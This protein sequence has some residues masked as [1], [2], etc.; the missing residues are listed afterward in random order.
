DNWKVS[1]RLTLNLGLRWDKWTPYSEKFNRLTTIDKDSVLDRFEVVTPGDHEIHSLP[2]IPPAVLDSWSAAGMTYATANQ[3]GYPSNLFR[4]DNNN[5]GPRLGAAYKITDK[6]VL[7]GGYGEYFWPM[8][9]SQILQSSRTNPP[10]NLRFANEPNFFDGSGTY[11]LRNTP[12][13]QFFL[14]NA[15]VDISGIQN[16]PSS[17]KGGLLW[18]G[19]NWKDARAQSWHVSLE[20]ELM[21][22]TALRLSYI[23]QH[24]RDL[25]QR[26]SINS[27]EAEFNYVLRTGL[28]P[29]GN[30]DQLLRQNP[31]WLG[32][33]ELNRTGFS[34]SHSAQIEIERKYS[35]G[36]AFQWFYTF[37]RS[38]TTTDTG[39]F[40]SGGTSINSGGSTDG[41]GAQVPENIQLFGEPNLTYDE[42]LHFAYFNSTAI[43]AHRIR[44]NG[45]VDLPFGRGKKLGGNVPAALDHV[46]GGWQIATI[47]DWRGGQ[48]SSVGGSR[49][50][51]GDPRLSPDQR[52]EMD[53][54]GTR[55]RLW[56]RG[57]FDPTQAT[58][59]TGGNLQDLVAVDPTQRVVRR[60]GPNA[61]N[62]LPQQLADGSIRNTSV[63]SDLFN[64]SPR[65]FIIGP[66]AWNVDLSF[67]KNFQIR[68]SVKARFTADFFNF[69]NHPNDVAPNNVT[70]LQRLD[71]QSNDPRIIQFSL[72]VDW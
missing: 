49:F 21:R 18:D 11:I 66:G 63:G 24:G 10:L 38:L 47:G 50:V 23:G 5:F 42:R 57:D 52:L 8:P 13:S 48:W 41:G 31:A 16:V 28:A 26:A 33:T 6:T 64:P 40:S 59:V 32:L 68:E 54:F 22:R 60:L 30:R 44:Y 14:P 70:G 61:N 15:T 62:Q 55:Q 69:F 35:N 71:R 45:I 12:G 53:I 36:I 2:G 27:R 56:F 34:N 43:P 29:T 58:N 3:V 19:R 17:S 25:E 51:F 72:R 1:S 4:A 37:T 9:L 46:I 7:R 39:G 20:R 65:G 67:F